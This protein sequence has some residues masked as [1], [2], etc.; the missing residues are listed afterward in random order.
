MTFVRLG[1][2]L[3]LRLGRSAT[4]SEIFV[5]APED[6]R[7]WDREVRR[8]ALGFLAR[9]KKA[10]PETETVEKALEEKV[11]AKTKRPRVRTV[12]SSPRVGVGGGRNQG[13]RGAGPAKDGGG[14]AHPRKDHRGRFTTTREGTEICYTFATGERGACEG[15]CDA[16]RAH[17]CQHCLQPHANARCAKSS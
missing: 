11:L 1:R 3:G 6:D 15:P 14:G 2:K 8:P 10:S 7:Y 17:V 5:E 4:W 12:P 16:N 13:G 9:G